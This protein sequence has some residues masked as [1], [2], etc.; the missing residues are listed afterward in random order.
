LSQGRKKSGNRDD[1]IIALLD[2]LGARM[3]RSEKNR[4]ALEE[5]VGKFDGLF[6]SL[7][8]R[9]ANSE[10]YF[11]N[12]Q[13]K[14]S[15]TEDLERRLNE[16][17]DRIER[18][19]KAQSEKLDRAAS[20]ATKMEEALAQ[21]AR[22]ARRLEKITQDRAR[23][24]HKLERIEE[25][26]LETRESLNAKALVLLTEQ[27][28]AGKTAAPQLPA[29]PAQNANQKNNAGTMRWWDRSAYQ[30]AFGTMAFIILLLAGGWAAGNIY[31]QRIG[32]VQ[33]SGDTASVAP[34]Q[35][36]TTKIEQDTPPP[37][38]AAPSIAATQDVA[39]QDIAVQDI[40]EMSDEELL[41]RMD[42]NPEELATA[43]N[44]IEPEM[45]TP[46]PE[47]IE[48][49]ATK[50]PASTTTT[51]DK[52]D[53]TVITPV[54]LT[55]QTQ[56]D[57]SE[58]KIIAKSTDVDSFVSAQKD[59][60]PLADRIKHDESL[61][62]VIK[63]IEQKAFEGIPEAQHDLAAI[64]TAGHGGVTIDYIK[65]AQWFREASINGVANARYNLGVLYHQGIGVEKNLDTAIGWYRAAAD[66]KHP[67]AQYNLGIAYI[68]GIGTDYNAGKAA[69]YF[70]QAA[71]AGIPEAAYNLGLI[72]ENGLL[73]APA[74]REA[75]Y[76]YKKA[77]DTGSPEA[78]TA[79]DHLAKSI[80]VSASE[81]DKIIKSK[82]PVVAKPKE[83]QKKAPAP[84]KSSKTS[85]STTST[86]AA[87]QPEPTAVPKA[88]AN[89]NVPKASSSDFTDIATTT[90]DDSA[91]I[92]QIQE[93]LMRLGLYPG[94]ADGIRGPQTE[95]AIRA[96]QKA[97]RLEKDGRPSQA[98]LVHL[99]TT[100]LSEDISTRIQ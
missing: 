82:E 77:A 91:L 27:G 1:T 43:L 14:I 33:T 75:L 95:D 30:K 93:Q 55:Q 90:I 19:Q 76:W 96:Y 36:A 17:Q 94:P 97:S 47:N 49:T 6:G 65:A 61:P 92:A 100:D 29:D 62:A 18:E 13:K 37:S 66:M 41:D 54:S 56:K 98:L 64:Y 78:Q 68:E 51:I 52:S 85:E 9:A 58:K 23:M 34:T 79:L 99:L 81:L 28:V 42:K 26:V 84:E 15:H 22:L 35:H 3:I 50:K 69:M 87:K 89:H 86:Q 24:I 53:K 80:N 25:T 44:K 72:L 11:Q 63:E 4:Q 8:S 48:K 70:E 57:V 12:I 40:M 31:L 39:A 7:E 21:Q 88:A 2:Q 60:R 32:N 71:N 5:S 38:F 74:P 20:L 83:T 59:A 73:G 16:R 67:E 45:G 10:R 46:V